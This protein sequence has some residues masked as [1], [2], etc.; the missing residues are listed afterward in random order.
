MAH[1][2]PE[3]PV[4]GNAPRDTSDPAPAQGPAWPRVLLA[5]LPAIVM[6]SVGASTIWGESGL[7]ARRQLERELVEANAELAAI[8][9]DN[10]RLLRELRLMDEDPVV[11]ERM[12]A[13]ELGWGAEGATIIRFVEGD[14]TE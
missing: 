9:R 7:L 10:Q 8:E 5:L 4:H 6:A 14:A 11:L 12:V 3:D 1:A 13:E 2:A